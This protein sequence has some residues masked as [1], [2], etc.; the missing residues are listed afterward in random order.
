MTAG[1]DSAISGWA[2]GDGVDLATYHDVIR[3]WLGP[4]LARTAWLNPIHALE[5]G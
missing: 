5:R 2:Q 1:L 4:E 3:D